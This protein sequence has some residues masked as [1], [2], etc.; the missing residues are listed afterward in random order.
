M[1]L[2][3]VVP[4]KPPAEAKS[5]LSTVL[6]PAARADLARRLFLHTLDTVD[7]WGRADQRL[8]VG[9]DEGLLKLAAQRGWVAVREEI[10]DLNCA[11]TQAAATAMHLGATTLLVVH[12]DLPLLTQSDLDGLLDRANARLVVVVAPCRRH[13][14]TNA[15]LLRPP[16]A[17]PF[18]YGPGSFAAHRQLAADRDIPVRLFHSPT[19]SFDL[20]TPEDWVHLTQLCHSS[21]ALRSRP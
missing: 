9:R 15:L 3:A 14:G 13:D 2:A 19:I 4:V 10:A 1:S 8:V 5:R 11:L 16:D 21:S 18:A 6:S 12:A 20:D 17:I 7:E